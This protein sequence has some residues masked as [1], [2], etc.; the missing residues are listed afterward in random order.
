MPRFGQGPGSKPFSSEIL[1]RPGLTRS[2]FTR[3]RQF[4]WCFD[5][6]RRRLSLRG[7][8]L[9]GNTLYGTTQQGR[10]GGAGAVFALT[11][12]SAPV[13]IP[14]NIQ[15]IDSAVVL[16]WN[17]LASAFSLQAAPAVAGVYTNV[18]GAVS[19]FTNAIARS[20]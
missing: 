9:S 2:R 1:Q 15:L 16:R 4:R 14:L 6:Q 8:G 12:A 7:F 13:P 3:L 5:Q 20:Q 19:P 10:R 18:P 17:D 11:L